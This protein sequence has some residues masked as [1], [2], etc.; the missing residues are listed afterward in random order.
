MSP[1]DNP[2]RDESLQ[3]SC[4]EVVFVA[5]DFDPPDGETMTPGERQHTFDLTDEEAAEIEK[6]LR[7]GTARPTMK[8]RRIAESA[9]PL[10]PFADDED[11]DLE[12]TDV[13]EERVN[14]PEEC[15]S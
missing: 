12:P 9:P 3:L 1:P 7:D 4:Q 11:D 13:F 2:G 10:S 14:S 5:S 15:Q 6:R 8:P